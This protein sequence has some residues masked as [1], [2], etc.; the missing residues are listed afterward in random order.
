[1]DCRAFALLTLAVPHLAA[2]PV[3]GVTD[4]EILIGTVTDLSGVGAIQGV[5]NSQA[6]CIAFDELNAKAAFTDVRSA[7]VE[8]HQYQ[9]P[10]AVP[11]VNKLLSR[12]G[13]FITIAVVKE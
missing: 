11:G 8:D 1:M 9:V 7:I 2:Q 12:D 5:N 6:I 3:R 10:R 4:T 13:V